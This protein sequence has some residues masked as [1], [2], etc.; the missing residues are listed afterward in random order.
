MRTST[1]I[2]H[3]TLLLICSVAHAEVMDKEPALSQVWLVAL[4]VAL[5]SFVACRY[6][7]LFALLTLPVPLLF[8]SSLVP[9]VA[10]PWV[11]PS[12]I[13]EAG[14]PYVVGC[15]GA[16]ILVAAAHLFGAFQWRRRKAS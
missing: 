12:I 16:V 4:P 1:T 10:D 15:G 2:V 6:N 14:W 5:L 8:L 11:G 13:A 7:P 3:L 9:E